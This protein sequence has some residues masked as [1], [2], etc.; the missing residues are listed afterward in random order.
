MAQ[1]YTIL[2]WPQSGRTWL[3]TMI[4]K[5]FEEYSGE[6]DLATKFSPYG[7]GKD[8]KN[9]GSY[10]LHTFPREH[11]D[12]A[13]LKIPDEI[14]YDK[15]YLYDMYGK[16]N[17]VPA[18]DVNAIFL[19]RHPRDC[20]VSNYNRKTQIKNPKVKFNGTLSEFIRY[21]KGSLISMIMWLNTWAREANKLNSSI[22]IRYE[23][24][25][26]NPFKSLRKVIN[27]LGYSNISDKIIQNAVEFAQFDNMKQMEQKEGNKHHIMFS[28]DK[29]FIRKGKI[30]YGK[31]S[32]NK[33]DN[34]YITK[35]IDKLNSCY[36]Y[37]PYSIIFSDQTLKI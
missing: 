24:L 28:K 37:K 10:N 18:K 5:V 13:W 36:G 15:T 35:W 23:D 3:I 7:F 17:K 19:T 9:L 14:Q 16:G 8:I 25:H 33:E 27:F 2:S 12:Q 31:Y 21:E 6:Y 34:E 30:G 4:G 11:E 1:E 29:P 20:I 22:L 26:I 32:F